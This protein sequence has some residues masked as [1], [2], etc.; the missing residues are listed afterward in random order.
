MTNDL[1]TKLLAFANTV[2]EALGH[3][4]TNEVISGIKG[5]ENYCVL[6]YIYYWGITVFYTVMWTAGANGVNGFEWFIVILAFLFDLGSW[7]EG[8]RGRRA[9]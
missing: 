8:R 4:S 7:A 1:T 5:N 3:P 6:F 9:A 2:R